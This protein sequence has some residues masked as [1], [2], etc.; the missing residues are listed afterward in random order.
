MTQA[1]QPAP[2]NEEALARAAIYDFWST[3]FLGAFDNPV[4]RE[5]AAEMPE[6]LSEC[7]PTSPKTVEPFPLPE[8]EALAKDFAKRF[9]GVGD[10]TFALTKSAWAENP[11]LLT[12]R[13]TSQVLDIYRRHGLAPKNEPAVLPSDHLGLMLGFLACLAQSEKPDDQAAEAPFFTEFVADWWPAAEQAAAAA[14]GVCA[15]LLHAFGDFVRRQAQT[16]GQQT[17]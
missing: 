6:L 17:A 2:A 12:G 10:A 16:F 8:A 9:Y 1:T 7:F 3:F 14:D 4:W 11:L 13:A 15:P 5:R